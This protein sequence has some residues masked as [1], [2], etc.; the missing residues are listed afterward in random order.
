MKI[1]K[2]ME[3]LI[4]WLLCLR[5]MKKTEMKFFWKTVPLTAHYCSSKPPQT[6]Y[7]RYSFSYLQTVHD[8]Y[9]CKYVKYSCFPIYWYNA[10]FLFTVYTSTVV[11]IIHTHMKYPAYGIRHILYMKYKHMQ[12]VRYEQV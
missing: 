2:S 7:R 9:T 3:C 4:W 8:I 6:I 11:Y 1:S 5:F 10:Y 12:V